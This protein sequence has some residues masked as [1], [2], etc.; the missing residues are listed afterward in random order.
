M[1]TKPLSKDFYSFIIFF[2]SILVITSLIQSLALLNAGFNVFTMGS[3]YP[4]LWLVFSVNAIVFGALVRYFL[5]HGYLAAAITYIILFIP[6][7]FQYALIFNVEL[8][9]QFQQ[10]YQN[11][12][13]V[14]FAANAL[15]ALSLIFTNA[16]QKRW[17]RLSGILLVIF[18]LLQAALLYSY[19]R[20]GDAG[21]K[22]LIERISRWSTFCEVTVPVC[23]LIHFRLENRRSV[24]PDYAPPKTLPALLKLAAFV[25]LLFLG[26]N[27]SVEAVSRGHAY[28]PSSTELRRSKLVEARYFVDQSGDTLPYRFLKPLDYDSAKQ[29]PLIVCLHHGGAHGKDN[30]H[31]LSA[32]PAP[33]LME[34]QNRAKY[35]AFI[36][37]P[38]SPERVGFSGMHGSPSV[39]SLVFRTIRQLQS[40]LPIDSKRIYVLGISGGGYGS[41][42]FISAH[43][44]LF[45]AAI[46]ICG[47]GDPKYG[48]KLVNTPI[49]AFHGA[50][51]KLAPV[52]HS[53]DMIEAIRKAGGKPKYT[54][55]EFSGHDIWGY[56][57]QEKGLMDWL[58]TQHK[59]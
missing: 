28:K 59:E 4:W 52:A 1:N 55:Y 18:S 57:K 19:F 17:L 6:A 3:F 58:F 37:M 8:R 27:F 26:F 16:G 32:D 11:V 25:G 47:G 49:W 29:Y 20:T 51:D 33:F 48:P 45:A 15:F 43:P 39:D 50:K 34:P 35:P 30:I 24:A 46:P 13:Y 44:E 14:L 42:H 9:V 53:R 2:L 40:E 31:Q 36:F 22:L 54:E 38:Q 41:W 21:T 12:S 56:V 10:Y 7:S 5:H 23:I